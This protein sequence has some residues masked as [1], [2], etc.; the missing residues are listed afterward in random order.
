MMAGERGWLRLH[1]GGGWTMQWLG[2][3]GRWD[4]VVAELLHAFQIPDEWKPGGLSQIQLLARLANLPHARYI[5]ED[6]DW[7]V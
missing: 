3:E 4:Q 7:E 5:G 2:A 6:R 1:E